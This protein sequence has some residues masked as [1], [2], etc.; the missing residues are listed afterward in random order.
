MYNNTVRR[1]KKFCKVCDK[2]LP[3]LNAKFCS[4]QCHSEHNYLNYI[5]NWKNGLEVGYSGKTKTLSNP[6]RRYMLSKANFSCEL[7]GWNA[8]HPDDGKPLVEI[9]HIDGN[10]SNCA[11]SNLR[12]LCPNC[13]SMTST[14]RSRNKNSAGLR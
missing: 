7:C 8:V 4:R 12:V 6:L 13:H 1:E 14:F 2:L 9:D 11:E 5:L 10:A 3:R